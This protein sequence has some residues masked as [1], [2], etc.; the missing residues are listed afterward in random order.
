MPGPQLSLY[1]SLAEQSLYPVDFL[2]QPLQLEPGT[3]R[4]WVLYT[5]ARAEKALALRLRGREIAYFLPLHESRPQRLRKRQAGAR[6]PL[7]SGYVFMFGGAAERLHALE[8][9]L[10]S[11]TL[12]V[13]EQAQLH[14]DLAQVYRLIESGASLL[15]ERRLEPGTVVEVTCGALEGTR[16]KVIAQAK[17]NRFIVEVRFLQQGVSTEIE[18]WMLRPVRAEVGIA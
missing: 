4:W 2:N 3:S 18:S 14:N 16:G 5:R 15:P 13:E 10:V 6:V 11:R 1:E 8:T 9:N 7:F 12:W 17:Q